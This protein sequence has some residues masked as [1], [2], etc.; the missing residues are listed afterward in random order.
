MYFLKLMSHFPLYVN[1]TFHYNHF[2]CIT[3]ADSE[4]YDV[5]QMTGFACF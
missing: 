5:T 1:Y 3:K 4:R 2:F